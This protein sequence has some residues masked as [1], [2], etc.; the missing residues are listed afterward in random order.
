MK[1]W[2][3]YASLFLP[4]VR[5][6]LGFLFLKVLLLRISMEEKKEIIRLCRSQ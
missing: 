5:W 2:G 1:I 6:D 4:V 3:N